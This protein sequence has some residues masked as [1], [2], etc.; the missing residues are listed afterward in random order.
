[1][2]L[3]PRLVVLWL[4][5]VLAAYPPPGSAQPSP[6]GSPSPGPADSPGPPGSPPGP[7]GG[8]FPPG[9]PQYGERSTLVRE[10]TSG[11][12]DSLVCIARGALLTEDFAGGDVDF[13]TWRLMPF[14]N[15]EWVSVKEG[16]LSIAG[17]L[18]RP[19]RNILFMNS[20]G[21]LVHLGLVSRRFPTADV[22]AVARMR[23]VSLPATQDGE[24]SSVFHLCSSVPDYFSEIR[25]G[26]LREGGL[27]WSFASQ[28]ERQS[29]SRALPAFGDESARFYTVKV[30]RDGPARVMTGY[31]EGANGWV[32]LG[33]A[34]N[35]N[36]FT[37]RLEL[38]IVGHTDGAD[39]DTRFDDVRLYPHPDRTPVRFVLTAAFPTFSYPAAG[40][41]SLA[42]KLY[43]A[44]G[45]TLIGEGRRATDGAFDVT[46]SRELTFPIGAVV[47]LLHN[48]KEVG[49]ARI[50]AKGVE[51]L[52]PGDVW[53]VNL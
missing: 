19:Q 50:T 15:R 24:W 41:E 22:V 35:T 13:Q 21:G 34:A 49:A 31:V 9:D 20:A 36:L 48:G 6:P 51:G 42:L 23:A 29:M 40:A 25:F 1:M 37:A 16:A 45:T 30:E 53:G 44:D 2:T 28:D 7:K 43:E 17:R 10:G 38:K 39:L 33:E 27:G 8:D 32:K 52:Y 26:S 12:V 11:I 3:R 47:R 18:Q 14:I 5:L 4:V 46:L